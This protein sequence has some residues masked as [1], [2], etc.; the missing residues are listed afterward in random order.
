[1]DRTDLES[2]A[3]WSLGELGELGELSGADRQNLVETICTDS[4]ALK[5]GD[6]FLALRGDNFDGH[7]FVA[8]AARRGALGAIVEEAP[9]DLPAGFA[10]IK[11]RDTLRALQQIAANYRRRLPLQVIGITGS[12]G[13]TSTKDLT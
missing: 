2:I 13:K 5:S 7:T 9:A 3:R 4:R 11:V 1:M 8:E 12:N 10:V 6:L